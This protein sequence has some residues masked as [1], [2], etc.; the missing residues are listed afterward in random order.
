MTEQMK[1]YTDGACQGNP[2]PGGW[3][4]VLERGARQTTLHGGE[5]HTTN[6]RMEMMAAIRALESLDKRCEVVLT[7][8]SQYVKN[9]ITQWIAGW[10]KRGWKTAQKTPVKN[11]DLWQRLDAAV[12]RH[13]VRW[14]WVRGHSGHPQN[15]QADRLAQ[16]GIDEL[17]RGEE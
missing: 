2:G 14:Q 5:S 7:T 6:N 15:E 9:G 8:D 13:Q 10:K 4:V 16:R 1:I 11:Q 12:A 3:G 17:R